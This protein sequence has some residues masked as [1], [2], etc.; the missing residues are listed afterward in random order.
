M[1]QSEPSESWQTTRE[2][3]VERN[4][5]MFNNPLLSDIK[6]VVLNAREESRVSRRVTIPA[7]KYVL[8]IS[9]PVFFAMFYGDLAESTDTIELSDCDSEGFL[10]L[11]RYLYC[12]ETTLSGNSVMQ[13]LYLAKKYIVPSLAKKCTDFLEENLD[14]VNVF[15]VLPQ[16]KKFDET[17]L[18]EQCWQIV[19]TKASEALKT[20]SFS[21]ID[22]ELLCEVIKRD[23]LS[24]KEMEIFK[25][26]DTWAT[27]ECRRR[28][29]EANG[30]NKREIMG[31]ALELIRFPLLGQKEFADT[32][33]STN[34]LQTDQIV[35]MFR[36]YS[37]LPSEHLMF[38]TKPR[39][40][41]ILQCKRFS[42][43]G[44]AWA[45][46]GGHVDAI[47][48]SVNFPIV[49]WGFRLFGSENS[50]YSNKMK[51]YNDLEEVIWSKEKTFDSVALEDRY[52]GYD[53]MMKKDGIVLEANRV[54]VIQALIN[55][56]SSQRGM[57]GRSAILAENVRFKFEFTKKST[58]GMNINEG[59]FPVIFFQKLA[60]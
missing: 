37:S 32:V 5:Y 7:H 27:Y 10:E 44:W 11:L 38:S 21:R 28:G 26:T 52:Y 19:D 25:A 53:V 4:R 41:Q 12:D 60:L 56:P 40:H 59:Q 15:A 55:G 31:S 50:Q 42:N 18:T 39:C 6:F 48:F 54:Y 57:G 3:I 58:N 35:A 30:S 23:S 17:E 46:G 33:L 8:A 34:V 29:V 13:V 14:A 2:S 43:Y 49:F 36:H 47:A 45:C 24:I 9:S 51:M 16:A 22:K 20:K 1:A